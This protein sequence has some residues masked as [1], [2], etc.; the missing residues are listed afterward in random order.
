[1][2][3]LQSPILD[4]RVLHQ[5]RAG[6]PSLPISLSVGVQLP[7]LLL[8]ISIKWRQWLS[9]HPALKYY[10]IINFLVGHLLV[11]VITLTNDT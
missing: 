7:L 5:L 10:L 1:L 3:Y 8:W 2:L 9:L 4:E 6:A 11:G